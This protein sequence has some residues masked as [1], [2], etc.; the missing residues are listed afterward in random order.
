[1]LEGRTSRRSGYQSLAQRDN[2]RKTSFEGFGNAVAV[3]LLLAAQPVFSPEEK[4]NV[5]ILFN[6]SLYQ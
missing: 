3:G 5:K 2:E 4:G 1:M 6:Y